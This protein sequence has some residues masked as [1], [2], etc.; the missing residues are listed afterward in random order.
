MKNTLSI[1]LQKDRC[2]PTCKEDIA[3]K[4]NM[5]VIV[6][7]VNIHVSYLNTNTYYNLYLMFLD[8]ILFWSVSSLN[9]KHHGGKDSYQSYSLIYSTSTIPGT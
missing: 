5:Q 3:R 9:H 6:N 1:I 2:L 4:H 7:V 8:F